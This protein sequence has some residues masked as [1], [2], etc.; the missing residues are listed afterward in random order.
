M[1][2]CPCACH[3]S[4]WRCGGAAPHLRKLAC[5]VSFIYRY[6]TTKDAG[7]R[8]TQH[9]NVG[10]QSSVWRPSTCDEDSNK[11]KSLQLKY[12]VSPI[13][14]LQIVFLW[15]MNR[16]VPGTWWWN[17]VS[18][19]ATSI[20]RTRNRKNVRSSS[21]TFSTCQTTRRHNSVHHNRNS[22][23]Y[24]CYIYLVSLCVFHKQYATVLVGY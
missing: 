14:E 17:A 16:A 13:S 2:S 6:P 7:K 1:Y 12:A 15:G 24:S 19:P 18:E 4:I 11:C 22:C 10:G 20:S 23:T 8:I 3:E 5:L 21:E 9:N